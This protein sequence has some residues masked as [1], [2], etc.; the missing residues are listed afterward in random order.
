LHA[1]LGVPLHAPE[2]TFELL[3]AILQLL[4]GTRE[5]PDLRFQPI[6]THGEVGRLRQA[7]AVRAAT[8]GVIGRRVVRRPIA[9]A[10]QLLKEAETALVLLR[11]RD[12]GAE[13]QGKKR[14]SDRPMRKA[15]H[16]R[17]E[18]LWFSPNG[19]DDIP[20]PPKQPSIRFA[21]TK[22]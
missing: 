5:L 19:P 8:I 2:L 7:P 6:E 17:Y 3:V 16:W 9:S 12:V 20:V 15:S 11:R 1:I 4:E 14:E 22:L 10:E 13:K 18:C 21:A